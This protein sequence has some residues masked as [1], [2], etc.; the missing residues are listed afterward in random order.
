[1]NKTNLIITILLGIIIIIFYSIFLPQNKYLWGNI[2]NKNLKWFIGISIMISVISYLIV[3]FLNILNNKDR[4]LYTIGN[5]IFLIGALLWPVFLYYRPTK[6]HS[7]ILALSITSLGALLIL[8][9][10]SVDRSI[11]GII[12][13]TYLF[14]HVFVMDNLI[15]SMSY[16][17]SF[18]NNAINAW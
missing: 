12:F 1:M 17:S 18:P 15:W 4:T 8:I 11:I 7:V 14:F 6:F 10:E 16:R 13:A 3:F 5:S 9:N 2:T